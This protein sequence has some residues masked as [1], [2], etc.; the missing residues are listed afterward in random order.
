VNTIAHWLAGHP[1]RTS[2]DKDSA[3]FKDGL[4]TFKARGCSGCHAY[5]GEGGTRKNHGPDLTG[6]GDNEW[7]QTMLLAPYLPS[8]YGLG[9]AMPLFRD[10]DRST[11]E[12]AREELD[13]VRTLLKQ[14]GKNEDEIKAAT[15]VAPL[16]D[17]ERELI[18]RFV[19][20]DPRTVFGGDP[21][22]GVGKTE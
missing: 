12:T 21:V 10:P 3:A 2:R 7:L 19:L 11:S 16:S 8:R 4:K 14:A 5:E 20:H 9:N 1:R 13:Q 22:A 18:I 15:R 6:Y 17:V